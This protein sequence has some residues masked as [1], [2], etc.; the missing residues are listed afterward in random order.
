VA[1]GLFY[2][3]ESEGPDVAALEGGDDDP[4]GPVA[5]AGD[6]GLQLRSAGNDHYPDVRLEL[7]S[8]APPRDA[9]TWEVTTEAGFTVSETGRVAVMSPFG[10]ESDATVTLP[11]LGPYRVRVH[12]QGQDQARDLGEATF[13]HGTE[14]WLLRIWAESR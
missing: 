7:W 12:V 11:A 1:Y 14:R 6:G 13:S 2:L 4:P 9:G 8:G 3:Q 10:E 5:A